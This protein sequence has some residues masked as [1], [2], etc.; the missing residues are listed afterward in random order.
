MLCPA[1]SLY[2]SPRSTYRIASVSISLLISAFSVP[3]ARLHAIIV[4]C[5]VIGNPFVQ[6][7]KATKEPP[8][9]S[10]TPSISKLEERLASERTLQQLAKERARLDPWPEMRQT[11]Y[12]AVSRTYRN[13]V[14]KY[15]P[16]APA[17]RWMAPLPSWRRSPAAPV[18]SEPRI[19]P[20]RL[21]F[22]PPAQKSTVKEPAVSMPAASLP[23]PSQSKPAVAPQTG[24]EDDPISLSDDED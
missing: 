24:T 16:V 9:K 17:P 14:D 11:T 12:T 6:T 20:S 8:A 18:V 3:R 15:R 22:M 1:L 10:T 4:L 2:I 23:A 5:H 7:P 19:H 13:D 21:R